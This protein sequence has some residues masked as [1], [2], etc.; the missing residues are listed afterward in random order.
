[1]NSVRS[2]IL[3]TLD[4]CSLEN[5]RFSSFADLP[6]GYPISVN[7]TSHTLS[8]DRFPIPITSRCSPQMTILVFDSSTVSVT[9]SVHRRRDRRRA[10]GVLAAADIACRSY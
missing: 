10:D 5:P 3:D 9:S 1:M 8:A 7:M 4:F 6:E 2:R